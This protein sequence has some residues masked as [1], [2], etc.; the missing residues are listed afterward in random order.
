M[1]KGHDE[2]TFTADETRETRQRVRQIMEA[3]GLSQADVA[4]DAA[5]KYGTFTGWLAGTYQ[6]NNDRIT[7]DVQIWLSSRAEKKRAAAV[8][9]QPPA[10]QLTASASTFLDTLRYAQIMPEIVIVSG[11]PGIGKTTSIRQYQATNR[12]VW[13]ATMDPTTAKVNGMLIELCEEMG[14]LEKAPAK[15]ARAVGRKVEGTGGLIVIDEAQHLDAKALDQLRSFYD[16]YNIGIALVGNE[17]VYRLI[18]GERQRANFAQLVSRIGM[19]IT[20]PRAKADD[21]CKLIAAWG[22]TDKD[23]I[24]LLKAIARKPGAL[25]SM[26]KVLQLASMMAAGSEETRGVKH[27]HAAWE[28]LSTNA[29]AA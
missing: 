26:T 20:Q 22:I 3:E 18:D 12:N 23:E 10:F 8:I 15:L 21:M 29:A 16:R 28:R 24:K 27:I 1:A 19:R 13:V 7:A 17:L 2:T 4:R 5:V 14:V 11:A 9:P 6:G 25:R